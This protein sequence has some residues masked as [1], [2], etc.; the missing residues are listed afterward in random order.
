MLGPPAPD[1]W[2][3]GS[4]LMEAERADPSHRSGSGER[5]LDLPAER[6]EIGRSVDGGESCVADERARVAS[7]RVVSAAVG[8][9]PWAPSR[10]LAY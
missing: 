10:S 8:S 6:G 9:A 5:R 4:P 1:A 2:P 7:A 3:L